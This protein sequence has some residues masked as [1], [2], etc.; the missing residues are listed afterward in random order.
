ME[1]FKKAVARVR[2]S[3][4]VRAARELKTR[5]FGQEITVYPTYGYRAPDGLDWKVPLRVWVH[6][7]RDTPFVES[8]VERLAENYFAKD[9][10]RPLRPEERARLVACLA[11]FIADDKSDESV[12]VRFAEDQ[13]ETVFPLNARTSHNGVIEET[14]SVPARI[15]EKLRGDPGSNNW[16]PLLARSGDGN[17]GGTG[18]VR[19]LD[20]DG[21]S[22]VSDIDDTVKITGVP[23]G[24]KTVIRNTFLQDFRAAP[25]MR[26]RY[27]GLLME[28]GPVADACFHYVSGSPWQLFSSLRTFLV[29]RE[30][31]PAGTF[32]MKNL[33]KNVL[34]PG[35]F[36]SLRGLA[37]GGDLATLDQKIRQITNLMVHLPGRKFILV[38]DSGEKDP[39]LYRALQRLFP[40][41]VKRIIIRDVLNERLSGMETISGPDVALSLDTSEVEGEMA[42]LIAEARSASPEAARL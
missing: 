6:D 34:E 35:A 21:L 11:N 12:S 26:D 19:F 4:V 14:I 37:L 9:L 16:R 30:Q 13:E 5:L 1:P 23:A 3:S 31:F 22:I 32:H 27:L 38:G 15:V 18:E 36:E 2:G 20:S 10:E 29:D 42:R 39:E 25:G 8:F 28:A 41:Q 24:K 7:N 33:R 40:Q 17:G